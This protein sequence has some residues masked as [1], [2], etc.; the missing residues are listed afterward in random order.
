M[1][2]VGKARADKFLIDLLNKTLKY[3]K[4]IIAKAITLVQYLKKYIG[5]YIKKREYEEI[6]D[7]LNNLV[8]YYNITANDIKIWDNKLSQ[9][10]E[11]LNEELQKKDIWML[12]VLLSEDYWC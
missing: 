4:L 7:G 3:D 6:E 11:V 12:L 8:D 1:E 5:T 9:L 2:L 10:S